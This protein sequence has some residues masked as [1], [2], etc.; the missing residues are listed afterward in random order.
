MYVQ[1]QNCSYHNRIQLNTSEG[2]FLVQRPIFHQKHN[3]CRLLCTWQYTTNRSGIKL[4]TL[5]SAT[6]LSFILKIAGIAQ[7]PTRNCITKMHFPVTQ[8]SAKLCKLAKKAFHYTIKNNAGMHFCRMH[9]MRNNSYM[10]L[11]GVMLRH[12]MQNAD[13]NTRLG[14]GGMQN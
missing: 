13:F 2:W 11:F 5:R 3:P 10:H 12:W 6:T 1:C 14:E 4:Q 7:Y 8:C 9:M